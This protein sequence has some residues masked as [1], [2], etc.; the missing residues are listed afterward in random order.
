[1]MTEAP[2]LTLTLK[3]VT[4]LFD[5]ESLVV[6]E[7]GVEDRLS[8]LSGLVGS[9]VGLARRSQWL[10][11]W[12]KWLDRDLE[13][14]FG[15][16]A[17]VRADDILRSLFEYPASEHGVSGRWINIDT[18]PKLPRLYELLSRVDWLPEKLHFLQGR[19]VHAHRQEMA[20]WLD[21][22]FRRWEDL[23]EQAAISHA[24]EGPYEAYLGHLRRQFEAGAFTVEVQTAL[25]AVSQSIFK[26]I[27]IAEIKAPDQEKLII[28][29]RIE[30]KDECLGAARHKPND[31]CDRLMVE[32]GTGVAHQRVKEIAYRV[33]IMLSELLQSMH[34]R[35]NQIAL[36]FILSQYGS[37]KP[38]FALT[39]KAPTLLTYRAVILEHLEKHDI[40]NLPV[41]N[42]LHLAEI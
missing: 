24:T 1:M 32:T 23:R 35:R 7:S 6:K 37:S 10:W 33:A 21:T 26:A 28:M 27:E 9:N 25:R 18:L 12:A 34:C 20:R 29:L 30:D 16:D 38:V 40:P 4:Y 42:N 17:D 39:F 3:D 31:N 13:P 15:I 22:E 11:Q 8:R 41:A 19:A 36:A 14:L 2:P 5:E